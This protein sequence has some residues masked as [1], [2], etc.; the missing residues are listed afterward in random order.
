[1]SGLAQIIAMIVTLFFV[2]LIVQRFINRSF[3]VLCAS[4]AASWIILLVASRLGAFQDTALLGLLVGG[5]VVGAFYAVKR[6]LLKALLL[7]QLPLLLSFLFVGYL[8]LGFIPDRVS[9]LLMV[10]IWIAFSI[11]YAYQSHSALRSLAGR[12]IACCRD[13]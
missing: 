11:I 10:S 1:M 4:W 12:I 8:L 7:F 6:R 2:L 5:S 9:I 3:C 13:W